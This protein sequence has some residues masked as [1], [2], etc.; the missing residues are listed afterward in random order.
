MTPVALLVQLL[1]A[2]PNIL[3]LV[4]KLIADVAAGKGQQPI[5]DADW[6]VLVALGFQTSEDIFKR[7]GVP[8]PPPT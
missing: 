6:A 8:L 4:Q 7:E 5:T 3:G 1:A 2:A